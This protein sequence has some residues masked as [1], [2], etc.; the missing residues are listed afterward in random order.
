M[1]PLTLVTALVLEV[2]NDPTL[3]DPQS[4]VLPLSLHQ[5]KRVFGWEGWT[6]TTNLQIQSLSFYH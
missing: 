1:L 6:R 2:G 4:D 3:S 5:V